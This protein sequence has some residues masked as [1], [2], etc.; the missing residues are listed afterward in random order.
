MKSYGSIW[1]AIVSEENL[2]EAWRRVRRGHASSAAVQEFEAGLE[3]NLAALRRRLVEGSYVPGGYR[4]FRIHDPKPRAISCAPVVDRVVHHALCSVITPLI[5]RS[6]VPVSFACRRGYGAH[7]ACVL[8]RRYAGDAKY[9]CKMDV[10][11][12]FDSIDHE[13]LL[14]VLLPKFREANVRRLIELIVRHSVPGLPSGCGLPIGNLTSQWFANL[15][16][17]AFDH[18]ALAGFGVRSPVGYLRYMDD[19]V[20]FTTSKAEVWRLHD[21]AKLWLEGERGLEVKDEATVVA[22]V[23]EGVPFLGLRIWSDCWRL[24]RA[25]FQ[26]TRRTFA[27]RVRQFG[28][29]ELDEK[30]FAQCAASSDGASRWFGFKGILSDLAP[31]EGSS[32]GSNRVKRGGSWNNN[33]DNCTSS[34]RNNNTPSNENNN[35]GFRLVS[36]MS[37]QTG[38]HSSTP[39]LRISGDKH[40]HLWSASSLGD[41]QTRDLFFYN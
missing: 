29:G 5:E 8:A 40:A 27:Q 4:Q 26:R 30:R 6:F 22:P 37:E 35:N 2:R 33:A 23:T 3:S 13:R 19:F 7:A 41:R 31:E 10:R 21:I 38:F 18:A 9:F 20:F 1:E 15:F 14:G 24:K 16:L 36:T 34:N 25:R 32:S 12:Y 17:S 28:R 11:K 39:A